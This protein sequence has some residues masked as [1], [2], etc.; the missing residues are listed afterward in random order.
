M[1]K[2]NFLTEVVSAFFGLFS[3]FDSNFTSKSRFDPYVLEI[4]SLDDGTFGV[5]FG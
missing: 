5:L 1:L 3:S 4:G 2:V